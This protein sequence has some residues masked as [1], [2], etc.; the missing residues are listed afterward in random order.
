MTVM[1]HR[2]TILLTGFG[3]F[4]GMPENESA[5]FVQKL[6]NLAA[7]RFSAHRI[8]ARVLPTEWQRGLEMVT[9]L[10]ARERPKVAVH[11]GVSSNAKGFVLER[12]GRNT[13]DLLLDAKG[14]LPPGPNVV[15]GG[16]PTAVPTWPADEIFE[17]LK[18]QA[19]P[20]E[21]SDDAGAYLCNALVYRT[22][23]LAAAS[24]VPMTTGFAH[25]PPVIPA[26][27]VRKKGVAHSGTFD[28]EVAL[29]GGLEIIR[30]CLGRPPP[31]RP[32]V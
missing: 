6:S 12:V 5:R 13:Q 24:E 31:A 22:A 29:A 16:P 21:Q 19:I 2:G 17:R 28:L 14:V 26:P 11:F 23:L 20:V 4:P 27:T 8:T 7:R 9:A 1:R 15:D 32:M 3:P 10:Y 18:Q 30:V 25:I